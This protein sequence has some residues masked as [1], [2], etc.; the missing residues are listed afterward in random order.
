MTTSTPSPSGW[1]ACVHPEGQRYH[2]SRIEGIHYITES[3]VCNEDEFE[4][5]R[6]FSAEIQTR[7]QRKRNNSEFPVNHE[8]E[9]VLELGRNEMKTPVWQYYIVDNTDRHIFW[10]E[11]HCADDLAEQ[12]G[13]IGEIGHL[14]T[15]SIMRRYLT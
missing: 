15:Y 12:V 13:G 1:Q 10:L 6:K 11:G 8:L 3:N 4:N 14:R 5:I 7:I 9:V 2:R